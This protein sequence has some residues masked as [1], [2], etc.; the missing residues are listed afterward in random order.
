MRV[1]RFHCEPDRLRR[2]LGWGLVGCGLFLAALLTQATR[3]SA[4]AAVVT[5]LALTSIGFGARVLLRGG[6]VVEADLDARTF[7]VVR[8]GKRAE[9]GSLDSFGPLSVRT[10]A[11]RVGD[12]GEERTI[13]EYVVNPA[14]P[15]ALDLCFA[16]TRERAR[17]KMERLARDWGVPCRS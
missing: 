4:P 6:P 17:K 5:V 2:H 10:L 13:E 9:S 8:K 16:P 11:H 12:I 3:V 7:A 14:S 1:V 15:A